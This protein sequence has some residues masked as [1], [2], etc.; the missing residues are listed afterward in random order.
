MERHPPQVHCY[1]DDTQLYV[2]FS[3][4]QSAAADAAIKSMTACISDVK[5]WMV[6]DNLTLND[7]IKKFLVH[8]IR[9]DKRIRFE[10]TTCGRGDFE[11]GKKKLRIQKYPEKCGQ[12]FS[13]IW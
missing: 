2:F 6:S 11:S 3:S 1:A 12:G 4:N 9:A 10:Y 5:S 13:F 7:D 8:R